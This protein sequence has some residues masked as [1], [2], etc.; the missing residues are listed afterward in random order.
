MPLLAHQKLAWLKGKVFKL[1]DKRPNLVFR[2]EYPMTIFRPVDYFGI[3]VINNCCLNVTKRWMNRIFEEVYGYS[4][5][6]DSGIAVEKPNLTNGMKDVRMVD[7]GE[8]RAGYFYQ[9]RLNQDGEVKENRVVIMRF[10]PVYCTEKTKQVTSKDLV[11]KITSFKF[12]SPPTDEK[13]ERFCKMIGMDYG[14]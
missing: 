9:Q 4:L 8:K 5:E 6:V 7:L 12:L 13:I 14:E 10:K 1:V 2:W 3:E 11:G